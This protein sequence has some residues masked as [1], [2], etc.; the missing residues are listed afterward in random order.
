MCATPAIAAP[1]LRTREGMELGRV[2]GVGTLAS[3]T[4]VAAAQA[5]PIPAD[6]RA[7]ATC[8]I[9]CSVATGVGAALF[10]A[11]LGRTPGAT[12]AVFGCGAVGISVILGARLAHAARIIAVDVQPQ[13]LEW[14]RQL[15]ATDAVDAT[16]GDPAKQ[17]KALTGGHGVEFAFEAVGIPD[18]LVQAVSACELGGTAVQIGVPVPGSTVTL[19]L[20]KLF[21]GRVTVKPT[22]GG[23]CLPAR[24]FPRLVDWYRTGALP[25]DA[26]VSETLAL[27]GVEQAFH[28][29]ERGETLR[30]VVRL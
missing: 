28:A 8:L 1:R 3:H 22:F 13:K 29:M 25:L 2:L 12:V 14:A 4:V 26:L 18:T 19:S 17:I 24:D 30:S 10:A 11:E 16:K 20:V 15:G 27:D 5:I 9:G 6:L 7:E 21:Y 23:D